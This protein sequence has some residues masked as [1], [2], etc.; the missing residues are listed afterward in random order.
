MPADIMAIMYVTFF[1][2]LT[3]LGAAASVPTGGAGFVDSIASLVRYAVERPGCAQ[4]AITVGYRARATLDPGG[5][6]GAI[7]EVRV[8]RTGP[9][10]AHAQ[11]HTTIVAHFATRGLPGTPG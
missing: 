7:R 1:A 3:A 4:V 11:P 6:T 8:V 9:G 5:D 10:Q 2:V